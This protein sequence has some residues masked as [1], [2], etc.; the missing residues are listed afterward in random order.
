MHFF[1]PLKG[2][3]SQTFHFQLSRFFLSVFFFLLLR[4]EEALVPPLFFCLSTDIRFGSSEFT[5]R[6]NWGRVARS[7]P[8][9]LSKSNFPSLIV[10]LLSPCPPWPR[11][12][13]R[14]FRDE[15]II[16]S[17]EGMKLAGI[18]V[19]CRYNLQQY[20]ALYFVLVDLASSQN[21][22]K[23]ITRATKPIPFRPTHRQTSI[24]NLCVVPDCVSF[25]A[26][27]KNT[28]CDFSSRK[29]P[30]VDRIHSSESERKIID[31]GDP[32]TE[33]VYI[34]RFTV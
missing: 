34:E 19:A 25:R 18:P 26:S 33:S 5:Y 2:S 28:G 20:A 14:R 13:T 30:A 10:P 16:R 6:S 29:P 17:S 9:E 23:Y 4:E 24:F 27:W 21:I 8:L 3:R 12:Y 32:I 31:R 11:V 1:A 15:R 22:T 7:N